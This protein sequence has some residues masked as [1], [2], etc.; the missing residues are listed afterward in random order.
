MRREQARRGGGGE[1]RREGRRRGVSLGL[2]CGHLPDSAPAPA[3]QKRRGATGR[4]ARPSPHSASGPCALNTPPKRSAP[5]PTP[6]P[7]GGFGGR[8]H[9][10]RGAKVSGAGVRTGGKGAG[11]PYSSARGQ[12]RRGGSLEPPGRGASGARGLLGQKVLWEQLLRP[13][14]ARPLGNAPPPAFTGR[15]APP[16]AP[17]LD[18]VTRAGAPPPRP[19]PRTPPPARERANE[20]AHSLLSTGRFP[21]TRAPFTAPTS[22]ASRHPA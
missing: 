19:P 3:P 11:A 7:P 9:L 8:A 20:R 10:G 13:P 5:A 1:G 18:H 14:A 17:P 2:L 12:C 16:E 21:R 22:P 15:A 4:G 6:P